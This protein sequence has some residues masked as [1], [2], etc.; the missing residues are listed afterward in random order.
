MSSPARWSLSPADE[1]LP[2]ASGAALA[3][4]RWPGAEPARSGAW[5]L[6]LHGGAFVGGSLDSGAP[7]AQLLAESAAQVVSLDYPLAPANPFPQAAEAAHAALLALD[8][9]RR[10]VAPHAPL[11]V[12]GEEAGGNI[13]AAAALMA[14]D[15][16]GPLL[17]GQIL[18][19]PM[20]DACIGTASQRA[21]RD[22]PLGCRCA[23]GW[24]AYLP[25]AGDAVHPYATPADSVRLAGLPPGLLITAND[26]PQ[27]DET[28]AF[29]R[30]L[31]AAGVA[32]R[33]VLL[34]MR[35]G[36]PCSLAMPDN[37][38]AAW[39]TPLR[40]TLRHFITTTTTTST[41]TPRENA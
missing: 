36:W 40:E 21:S 16:A 41:A 19:S 6:H 7:V 25:E 34:P 3:V 37:S 20:L 29:D 35:T 38:Q 27:R 22:G 18:L 17:A 23:D 39:I 8:R 13:A 26:D 14:R 10:R 1:T 33:A 24:R 28:L 15:R 11:L 30:R 32:S 12:A 5:I 4:R 9:Q 31:R 2:L